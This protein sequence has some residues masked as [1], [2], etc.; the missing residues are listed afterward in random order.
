MKKASYQDMELGN[1]FFGNSRGE[2][3]VEPRRAYQ[4]AF[5]DF[6]NKAGFDGYG[7][8]TGDKVKDRISEEDAAFENETFIIRPYYWGENQEIAQRPNF[9]Y[10]PTNLA[11]SWYKYPMRDAYSNQDISV[12]DF[13][14]VCE[15][16]LK[17][18]EHPTGKPVVAKTSNKASRKKKP[19]T[20]PGP[21]KAEAVRSANDFGYTSRRS[22]DEVQRLGVIMESIVLDNKEAME[23]LSL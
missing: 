13:Q 10:K 1:L 3:S 21:E 23:E 9:V 22:I 19:D 8:A 2:F 17:S 4:D 15:A 6:L 20:K 12:N 5:Y 11:M 16:C 14:A 7:Y 18:I